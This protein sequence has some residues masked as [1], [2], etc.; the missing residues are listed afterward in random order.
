MEFVNVS[1]S[2]WQKHEPRL[3]V[4]ALSAPGFSRSPAT[5]FSAVCAYNAYLSGAA[6]R[7]RADHGLRSAQFVLL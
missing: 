6:M 3:P 1:G 7:G 5:E 4:G 2:I